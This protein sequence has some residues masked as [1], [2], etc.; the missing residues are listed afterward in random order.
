MIIPRLLLT[1]AFTLLATFG[2]EGV[3]QMENLSRG[4]V[5]IQDGEKVFVSWRLLGTEP[6]DTGFNVYRVSGSEGPMKLNG[7]A[8]TDVT[9]FI[10]ERPG[11]TQ[12][13]SYTVRAVVDGREQPAS[14]PFAHLA[15]VT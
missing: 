9:F 15:A 13:C 4:V 6:R 2:A 3:P 5:A 8:I 12:E 7:A 1:A 14:K 11:L 10:D